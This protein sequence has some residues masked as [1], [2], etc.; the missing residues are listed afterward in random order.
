MQNSLLLRILQ[1]AHR[2]TAQ[3][4]SEPLDEFNVGFTLIEML[5]VVIIIA[6]L[7]AIAAPGWLAFTNRQRISKYND[8][9]F[10]AL[11]NAQS[12][13]RKKKLSQTVQFR[14]D[15]LTQQPQVSVYNPSQVDPP[16]PLVPVPPSWQPLS[17][18]TELKDNQFALST[19]TANS[20]T[21]DY[22]GSIKSIDIR[23]LASGKV[24]RNIS[25]P[26]IANTPI[27]GVTVSLK[28]SQS[29]RCVLVLT[30]IGT[31]KIPND[32]SLCP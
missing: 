26:L 32:T 9:V 22:Q 20:I 24:T 27:F 18:N 6:V 4:Q 2:K 5:V 15:P 16:I 30:L 10:S 7:S 28:N 13:A 21:F 1:R 25:N 23:D 12:E 8:S 31:M 14:T 11:Q 3:E 29:K 17:Q 19:P